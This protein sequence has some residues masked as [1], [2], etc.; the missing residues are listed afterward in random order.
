MFG[1]GSAFDK[2]KGNKRVALVSWLLTRRGAEESYG[3]LKL[4]HSLLSLRICLA[5]CEGCV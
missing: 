3:D 1:D 5:G 2:I 4:P